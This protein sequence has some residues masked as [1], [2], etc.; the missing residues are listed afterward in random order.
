MKV[1]SLMNQKGGVGKTTSTINLGAC[2]SAKG[3]KV[4][5]IDTDPQGNLT[6]SAGATVEAGNITLYEVLTKDQDINKAIIQLDKYDLLPCDILL[7]K[8]DLELVNIPGNEFLLKEAVANLNKEYDFIL[9][10]N[11]PALNR[12][13]LMNMT[14]SDFI[15]IPIQ[16]QFLAMGGFN[17]LVET[18]DTVKK[19]L[20]HNI[21]IMGAFLTMYDAR[22][23]LDTTILEN[24]KNIFPGGIFETKIN[25]NVSLAEAPAYG[26][27]IIEYKPK[28]S[29]ALQYTELT[30]ELLA[31]IK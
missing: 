25:V 28:S 13:T 27:D 26:N 5:L 23:N 17:Q 9:I 21:K 4:L 15:L 6:Q 20:N 18:I 29:G 12:I 3:Y 8:A 11:P 1:I 2:L 24:L 19:R 16:S 7:S 30:N 22:K 31:K 10:D 14:A